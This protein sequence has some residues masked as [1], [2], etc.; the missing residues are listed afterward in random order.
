MTEAKSVE[1]NAIFVAQ[2][3][4]NIQIALQSLNG[5]TYATTQHRE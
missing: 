4:F 3:L 2:E 1:S 5:R